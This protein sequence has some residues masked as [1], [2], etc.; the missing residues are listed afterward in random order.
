[1]RAL[2]TDPLVVLF[3]PASHDIEPSLIE[4]RFKTHDVFSA[5]SSES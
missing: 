4:Q 3:E 2:A 1:V 5:Q